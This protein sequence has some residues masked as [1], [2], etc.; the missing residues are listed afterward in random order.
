MWLF[1]NVLQW[2]YFTSIQYK[3]YGKSMLHS[4]H[5]QKLWLIHQ[6]VTPEPQYIL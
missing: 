2:S 1:Q 5:R 4:L 3:I 6:L